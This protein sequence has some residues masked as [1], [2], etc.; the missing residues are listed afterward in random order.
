MVAIEGDL[1]RLKGN[2]TGGTRKM[3]RVVVCVSVCALRL[4]SEEGDEGDDVGG[5]PQ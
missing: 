3:G 2:R 5:M 4:R 1:Q